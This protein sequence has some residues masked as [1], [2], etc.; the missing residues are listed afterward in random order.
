MTV[1]AVNVNLWITP[2]EANL[3]P[4]SG[5][6]VIYTS[7]PPPDWNF[8]EFNTDTDRVVDEILA[9][10][11]F[12]NVTV[13]YRENRI[14]IFDSALFHNTDHFRFAPGYTNRRINLTFLYGKMQTG[15]SAR[16][17]L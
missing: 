13:P 3:D 4:T 2:D 1:A 11:G 17:D 12:A 15:A 10:T 7:K 6:L 16:S 14:V 8:Q 5:G 9:P